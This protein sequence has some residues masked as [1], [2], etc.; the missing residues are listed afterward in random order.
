M[1]DGNNLLRMMEEAA[2]ADISEIDEDG[3]R[4]LTSLAEELHDLRERLIPEAE[5]ALQRLKDR[6][7]QLSEDAIPEAMDDIGVASFRLKD[8][9]EIKVVPDLFVSIRDSVRALGWLRDNGHEGIIKHVVSASFG[10][11]E[12]E[13][14]HEVVRMLEEAGVSPEDKETVAPQTLRKWA[15][16]Q[17]GEGHEVPEA[18]FKLFEF[19][20]TKI[21]TPRVRG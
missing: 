17:L 5:A 8:G 14:A 11:G 3:L 19:R 4:N 2:A 6:D 12:E 16:D 20:K 10:R 9:S 15:K 18:L 21:T 1:D 13:R 7:R